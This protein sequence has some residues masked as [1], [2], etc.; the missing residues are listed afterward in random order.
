MPPTFGCWGDGGTLLQA[1]SICG[2]PS[3][4][5]SPPYAQNPPAPCAPQP[6][7]PQLATQPLTIVPASPQH[8]KHCV[9]VLLGRERL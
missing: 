6:L 9:L 5:Q 4:S 8:Q 3:C 2:T 7:P 1:L